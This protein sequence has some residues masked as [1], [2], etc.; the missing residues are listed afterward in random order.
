[1]R[2]DFGT[3]RTGGGAFERQFLS[4][5]V[6]GPDGLIARMEHF[7]S[8][9]HD[10]ALARFDALTGA[11]MPA[12]LIANAA[13]RAT[14]RLREGWAAGDWDRV[15]EAFGPKFRLIDRRSY[16]HLELDRDRN[17]ESMRMRFEMTSSR[18]RAEVLATRGE[19]CA[20]ERTRFELADG[21]VGP[22]E[23]ES[24]SVVEVDARGAL[25]TTVTFNAD[26]LDAAYA[27]LDDRYAAGEA[28]RTSSPGRHGSGASEPSRPGTGG[29]RFRVHRGLRPG[30]PPADR[31]GDVA[32]GR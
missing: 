14:A 28:A 24:L 13:T 30:G 32:L 7:D 1:V 19:R 21:D 2:D 29:A 3:S 31:M 11:A 4:L 8:D 15:A 23:S 16:A 6:F 20:L 9:Q 25:E 10:R 18:V 26:Q 17:L 12:V 27:E 5:M 22:S